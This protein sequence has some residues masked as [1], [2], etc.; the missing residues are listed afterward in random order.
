MVLTPDVV[1]TIHHEGG[2]ILGAG[3]GGDLEKAF[4]FFERYHINQLYVIGGDGSMRGANVLFQM[5]K[6]KVG[7]PCCCGTAHA[8]LASVVTAFMAD[9][10]DGA[11]VLCAGFLLCVLTVDLSPGPAHRSCRCP[12]DH[13]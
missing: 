9:V 10:S 2:S 4:P 12:E 6:A 13:R 11:V 7:V 3:R 5:I 8:V 1:A